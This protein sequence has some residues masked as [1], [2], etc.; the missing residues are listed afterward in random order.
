MKTLRKCLSLVLSLCIATYALPGLASSASSETNAVKVELTDQAMSQAVGAGNLDATMADVRNA[1]TVVRATLSNR[2]IL[3][4]TY[5][6]NVVDTNGV[7]V[8]ALAS[9]SLA[10]NAAAMISATPAA[11]LTKIIQ[12]RI[13]NSG[14]PGLLSVDTSWPVN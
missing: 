8:S 13:T 9:G 5:T 10:P 1:D 12:A 4:C 14:V 7:L 6:M 3:T 2:S 11:G